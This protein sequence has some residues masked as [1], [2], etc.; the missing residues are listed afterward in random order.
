MVNT[1]TRTIAVQALFA[2]K[3]NSLSPGMFTHVLQQIGTTKRYVNPETAVSADV[4][5]YYVSCYRSRQKL[6]FKRATLKRSGT[7]I[8]G[9]KPTYYYYF[10]VSRNYKMA[11]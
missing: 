5:G 3:K 8:S 1:T 11:Q 4:R 7:V 6:T 2:N 9:L 10:L